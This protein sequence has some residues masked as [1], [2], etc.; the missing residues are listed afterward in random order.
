M[1]VEIT[2]A[3]RVR[4]RIFFGLPPGVANLSAGVTYFVGAGA[5]GTE[6]AVKQPAA[7][8]MIVNKL[9]VITATAP[10][11]T[12]TQVWTL[13]KNGADTAITCTI[14]GAATT[15]NDTAHSV[16]FVPTDTIDL[17]LVMSAA[18]ATTQSVMCAID[19]QVRA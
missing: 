11:G 13:R 16:S 17:K 5:S 15:A 2:R 9:Y 10:G 3:A 18:A 7:V 14:T 8:A 12:E 19:A 4:S 1:T 6:A